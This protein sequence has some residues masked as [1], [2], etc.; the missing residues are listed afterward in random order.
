MKIFFKNEKRAKKYLSNIHEVLNIAAKYFN[1]TS[2][3]LE[4]NVMFTTKLEIKKLNKTLRGVNEV[5]D[6]LAFP[7]LNLNNKE[8]L[9][10]LDSC[11]AL[12]VNPQTNNISLGDIALCIPKCLS[13]AKQYGTTQ[14]R[15]IC[16]LIL[17]G[18]LHLIG[19]NH[20]Q[21]KDKLLMRTK[22]EEIFAL[23]N[24]D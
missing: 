15:E 1:L 21:E 20:I 12:D 9:S 8:L 23:F 4:V 11:G 16:Y 24:C 2:Y 13:Q 3:N 6:V 17:H 18:F 7:N 19:Y 14:T 5:T 22:E 10:D